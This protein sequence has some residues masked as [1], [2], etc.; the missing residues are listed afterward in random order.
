[1]LIRLATGMCL[2]DMTHLSVLKRNV[3]CIFTP[4]FKVK[5]MMKDGV[6]FP[7]FLLLT[8]YNHEK[9][10]VCLFKTSAIKDVEINSR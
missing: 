8:G 4:Y 10:L 6:I 3:T 5:Y 9:L 7:H 1:M 2:E